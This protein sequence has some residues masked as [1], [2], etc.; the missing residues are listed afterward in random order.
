M[1]FSAFQRRVHENSPADKNQH[2]I[3]RLRR[4][5]ASLKLKFERGESARRKTRLADMIESVE[6]R[7][8]VYAKLRTISDNFYDLFRIK[9]GNYC[10]DGL[11]EVCCWLAR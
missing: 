9:E 1:L 3:N 11:N 10:H 5:F 2:H 6:R 7:I 8:F 4:F